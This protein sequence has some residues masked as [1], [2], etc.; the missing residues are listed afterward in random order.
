MITIIQQPLQE[1]RTPENSCLWLA[2]CMVGGRHFEARSRRGA[3]AE[4]AR[5]LVAAGVPDQAVV[6]DAVVGGHLRRGALTYRSLRR[7]AGWTWT[8]GDRPLQCVPYRSPSEWVARLSER[9]QNGG[10]TPAPVHPDALDL[11]AV[12]IAAK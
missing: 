6:V 12:E 7:L 8:E 9:P 10:G 11:I 2:E 4:L 1:T 3:P 5:T